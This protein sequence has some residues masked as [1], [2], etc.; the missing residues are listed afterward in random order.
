M[1]GKQAKEGSKAKEAGLKCP[2]CP[3][4]LKTE[5]ARKGH[6][7]R[8]HKK[9][10]IELK[11]L[12]RRINLIEKSGSYEAQMP[13]AEPI[14]PIPAPK[15]RKRIVWGLPRKYDALIFLSIWGAAI[16]LVVFV[17]KDS[18]LQRLEFQSALLFSTVFLI[19]VV[20]L[21]EFKR[22]PKK[23]KEEKVKGKK[24]PK[25]ARDKFYSELH[26]NAFGLAKAF[27]PRLHIVIICGYILYAM[28]WEMMRGNADFMLDW[29]A[30][31][32]LATLVE[33]TTSQ[34]AFQFWLDNYGILFVLVMTIVVLVLV[35]FY[36]SFWRLVFKD[37]WKFSEGSR[38]FEGRCY[39]RT[40]GALMRWWDRKYGSPT[41]TQNSYWIKIGWWPPLNLVNPTN[42]LIRLD[43]SLREK[44]TQKGI[45]AISVEELP[46]R[47]K[48]GNEPKHW[49]T[50]GG[51]YEN[52]AIPN[53]YAQDYFTLRSKVLVDDTTDLSF[54]NADT[55]NS[56]MLDGLR[57]S[58]PSI[59]RFILDSRERK[60]DSN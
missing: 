60:P 20:V 10:Q 39:W 43:T 40:N 24:E 47:R 6:I 3:K 19:S 7:T 27:L 37:Y 52:G 9:E 42:S 54:G 8:F 50:Y 30:A 46:L 36:Y 59:R 15:E 33:F 25:K 51:A 1:G 31:S 57:L 48:V 2:Q 23:V 41:R 38:R 14:L 28:Y 17:F 53:K 55:R 12:A 35:V 13:P 29:Y 44:C 45:Y 34:T 56:V 32:P 58:K 5:A 4:I 26:P 16:L 49:T 18:L 11:D 21:T 22:R